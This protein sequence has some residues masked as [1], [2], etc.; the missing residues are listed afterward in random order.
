MVDDQG[1]ATIQSVAPLVELG[2][3]ARWALAAELDLPDLEE[4]RSSLEQVYLEHTRAV[5]TAEA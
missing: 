4:R 3:L 1:R 5:G 2:Q